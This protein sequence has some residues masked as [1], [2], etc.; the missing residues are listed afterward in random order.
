MVV[1]ETGLFLSFEGGDGAGK[2]LQAPL[3][4]Q[5][6][7]AQGVD[8]VLTREP[9]GTELGREIRHLLLHGDHIGPRAE[10]LLYA[11][12]R[13][14]HVD[15]VVRPALARGAVVITDRYLD[16]SVA[17]QA[18]GRELDGDD[19]ERLS[20][21]AVEDLLPD[22]TILLDLDAAEA[23]GRLGGTVDRIESAGAQFH[24]RVRD[25]YL[26]RA[27]RDP[28]RWR[29]VDGSGTPE[30]VSA[31]VRAAVAP[32]LGL[33]QEPP[34]PGH[35]VLPGLAEAAGSSGESAR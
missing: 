18:H 6:L 1:T 7:R 33:L 29:V 15:T 17:Y 30:Q 12:D 32:L 28:R 16:S 27:A 2:S 13:A 19:V 10:A 23:A 22:A 9:G 21:W 11:A 8:V 4:G 25:S 34:A 14:H 24:Q 5:W 26:D 35:R 31:A 3:L 20:L